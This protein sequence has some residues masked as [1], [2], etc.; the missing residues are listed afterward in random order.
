V[1]ATPEQLDEWGYEVSEVPSVE[2]KLAECAAQTETDAR[3]QCWADVD[4]ILMEE[5]VPWVPYLFDTNVDIISERIVNYSFDQ[6]AGL[7]A[8][9]QFA[10]AAEAQ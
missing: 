4:R 6:F 7:A 3:F 2:E 9:D 5:V 8:F 10:I 1:G